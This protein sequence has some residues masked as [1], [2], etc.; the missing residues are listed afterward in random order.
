MALLDPDGLVTRHDSF[1]QIGAALGGALDCS[2]PIP[3]VPPALGSTPMIE[4]FLAA[5]QP[6]GLYFAP[7]TLAAGGDLFAGLPPS[8]R[9]VIQIFDSNPSTCQMMSGDAAATPTAMEAMDLRATWGANSYFVALASQPN[10]PST[11][12]MQT[13]ADGGTGVA[14]SPWW[15]VITNVQDLKLALAEVMR[16]IRGCTLDLP[17]SIDPDVVPE[18][19]VSLNG[20]FIP[21]ADWSVD[22][23]QLTLLGASCDAYLLTVPPPPVV[24]TFLCP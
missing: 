12:Y 18:G 17:V 21:T 2:M 6:D 4:T 22:G 11:F 23:A 3:T 20:T 14:G 15:R 24:A 7:E 19:V 1:V 8:R 5:Y 16:G 10:D 13:V 9:A